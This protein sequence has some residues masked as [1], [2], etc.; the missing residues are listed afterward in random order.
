MKKLAIVVL[1]VFFSMI[2]LP[3]ITSD[4]SNASLPA[5][6]QNTISSPQYVYEGEN[7]TIYMN[8]TYGFQNYTGV[9]YF[10]GD[11]L[12]GLHN[13]TT[14][15]FPYHSYSMEVNITAPY[16]EEQLNIMGEV[17]DNTS[18]QLYSAKA[19]A[20]VKILPP[21]NITIQLRNPGMTAIYNLT[22]NFTLDGAFV[23]SKTISEL[24]PYSTLT[25]TLELAYPHLNQ[26]LHTFTVTVNKPTAS[27]NGGFS[28]YQG[29]F[30]YG[31]PPS[32]TWIYYIAAAVIAFMALLVLS[33]GRRNARLKKPK[34][35]K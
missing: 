27:I 3:V 21:L 25:V 32:Y 34:W 9:M 16:Y 28:T 4:N 6:F 26:G 17:W 30:Y 20:T 19:I 1:A 23:G 2:F 15:Y 35:K 11:N 22:A 13:S 7:F 33:S 31:N 5:I 8:T 14:Q 18:S 29:Q 24:A 12:S 10:Y